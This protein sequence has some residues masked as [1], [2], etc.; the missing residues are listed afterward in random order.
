MIKITSRIAGIEKIKKTS[1]WSLENS[2]KQF[3]NESVPT[4]FGLLIFFTFFSLALYTGIEPYYS[5]TPKITYNIISNKLNENLE[6][7]KYVDSK[8]VKVVGSSKSALIL[9]SQLKNE[10]KVEILIEKQEKKYVLIIISIVVLILL[11]IR[12]II[13]IK[14]DIHHFKLKKIYNALK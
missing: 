5:P 4:Y 3:L 2:R 11:V 1:S 12:I 13:N 9:N 10:F 8:K 14:E 6:D 7:I